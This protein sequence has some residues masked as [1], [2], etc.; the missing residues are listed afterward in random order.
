M[1]NGETNEIV[2]ES[3]S[4]SLLTRMELQESIQD[5]HS[6]ISNHEEKIHKLQSS[7]LREHEKLE[8]IMNL[9]TATKQELE[10][11]SKLKL[12]LEER[13]NATILREQKL[14][15]SL[16]ECYGKISDCEQS[17][18]DFTLD[19]ERIIRTISD[20][21]QELESILRKKQQN[22][23][24]LIS[25][26]GFSGPFKNGVQSFTL[27]STY[28]S[29]INFD[30]N[31]LIKDGESATL[32][33]KSSMLAPIP[34]ISDLERMKEKL[35]R[36]T[37]TSAKNQLQEKLKISIASIRQELEV[38]VIKTIAAFM[39]TKG[40]IL[41][42]GIDDNGT[43]VGI[44]NDFFVLASIKNYDSWLQHLKSLVMNH[45]GINFI[46]YINAK[47]VSVD[48]KTVSII[49]VKRAPAPV[50]MDYVAKGQKRTDFFFRALNTTE[51]LNPKH[52]IDYINSNWPPK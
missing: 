7:I 22:L 15:T 29:E 50:F 3:Q 9:V 20:E 37:D 27:Q 14:Q 41:L 48:G 44:E 52:Q 2:N 16:S 1:S 23:T 42:V 47:M 13:L 18:N 28:N 33:F 10:E 32:E 35:S 49:E 43:I 30:L 21:R 39:N 5:L 4:Q 40:G 8:P 25:D 17:I 34:T 36:T 38:E 31:Q 12:D 46:S 51:V 26:I 6:K 45:L 11:Q 19:Q 24:D